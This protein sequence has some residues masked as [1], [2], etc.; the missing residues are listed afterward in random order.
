MPNLDE[1]EFVRT[2]DFRHIPRYLFEQVE[3]LDSAMVDRIYELGS[4]FT[5]SPLTLLY[6]LV[7]VD[8]K[9]KGV[10]WAAIDIIEAVF[11]IKVLSLDKE[12]QSPTNKILLKVRDFLMNL[13]TGP[14]LKKEIHFLTLHSDISSEHKAI[15]LKRS[16]RILLEW[17][18]NEELNRTNNKSGTKWH[19]TPDT[20]K[21]IKQ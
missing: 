14:K 9:I 19:S 21:P 3:E 18:D 10:L 20:N 5:T 15:G 1:L 4:I 2:F 16:K 7:D 17:R 13:K 8:Y 12:Y 11:F 6:V